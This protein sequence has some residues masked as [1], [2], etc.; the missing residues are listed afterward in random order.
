MGQEL[1]KFRAFQLGYFFNGS[2]PEMFCF[3]PFEN[4][5]PLCALIPP[6][7]NKVNL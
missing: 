1:A 2:S 6:I 4:G 3:K 5:L 7:K